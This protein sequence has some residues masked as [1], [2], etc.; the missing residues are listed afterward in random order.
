MARK[1]RPITATVRIV[2]KRKVNGVNAL[3]VRI[4]KMHG[5]DVIPTKMLL[6]HVRRRGDKLYGTHGVYEVVQ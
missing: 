4:L 1:Q 3:C 5:V 6:G 2:G